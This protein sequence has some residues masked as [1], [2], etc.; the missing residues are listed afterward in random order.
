MTLIDYHFFRDTQER[1]NLMIRHESE[2]RMSR[3]EYSVHHSFDE[4]RSIF[5]LHSLSWA[6]QW[7]VE[8]LS[9]K[10]HSFRSC[11]DTLRK[12][13]MSISIDRIRLSRSMLWMSF[14]TSNSSRCLKFSQWWLHTFYEANRDIFQSCQL[15]DV[16]QLIRY[17]FWFSCWMHTAWILER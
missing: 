11:E 12:R 14:A 17:L 3:F 7:I 10:E 15:S 16:F 4:Q 8:L 5:E 1:Q 2:S 13:A 6:L 9:M